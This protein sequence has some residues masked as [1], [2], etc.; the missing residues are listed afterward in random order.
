MRFGSLIL[1]VLLMAVSAG[2][3]ENRFA[4]EPMPDAARYKAC[5]ARTASTPEVARQ[6]AELWLAHDGGV[7]AKHCLALAL[8]GLGQAEKAAQ[9]LEEAARNVGAGAGLQA[10]GAEGG[11]DVE[12]RLLVQGGNAWIL[13]RRF[14]RARRAFGQA[15]ALLPQTDPARVDIF[16]DR[17]RAA[18]AEG[19]WAEAIDDLS[20]AIAEDESR[21]DGE[22]PAE[23]GARADLYVLRAAAER[24]L[25]RFADADRD[26]ARAL[27][28][29]P[30]DAGALLE[31]GN[32]R[33]TEGDNAAARSD[34]ERVADLYPGTEEAEIA[35]DNLE[36]MRAE[37]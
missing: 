4:G 10:L 15:L 21:S 13:A 3:Q 17:S 11:A 12:A 23:D 32:L 25:G 19:A 29:D 1:L 22:S 37:P 7:P 6:A 2:A 27:A 33:R 16:V 9:W 36:L 18:A 20:R 31:R 26:L 5:V 30:D 8:L 34:W 35:L 14:D 24:T 28:I